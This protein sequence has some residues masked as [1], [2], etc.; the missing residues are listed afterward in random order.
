MSFVSH[1]TVEIQR[2][3]LSASGLGV[4]VGGELGSFTVIMELNIEFQ[5]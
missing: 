2:L 1:S 5:Q 4:G 3:C